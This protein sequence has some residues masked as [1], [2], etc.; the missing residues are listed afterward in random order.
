MSKKTHLLEVHCTVHFALNPSVSRTVLTTSFPS[1]KTPLGIYKFAYF[2]RYCPTCLACGNID[3]SPSPMTDSHARSEKATVNRLKF[4]RIHGLSRRSAPWS[5]AVGQRP[6]IRLFFS[7]TLGMKVPSGKLC[8][9]VLAVT[10][11]E[12]PAPVVGC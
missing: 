1:L 8:R 3:S 2:S 9:R 5:I 6:P 10:S 12:G 11:P 4:V 7:K